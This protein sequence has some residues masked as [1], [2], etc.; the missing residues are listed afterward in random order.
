MVTVEQYEKDRDILTDELFKPIFV[1]S[2]E[3]IMQMIAGFKLKR[4][5]GCCEKNKTFCENTLNKGE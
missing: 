3:Q 1:Y 2:H 4:S 5:G